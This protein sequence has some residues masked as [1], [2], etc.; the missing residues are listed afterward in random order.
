MAPP[1]RSCRENNGPGRKGL[2][3]IILRVIQEGAQ[4][5]KCWTSRRGSLREIGELNLNDFNQHPGSQGRAESASPLL[6]SC[7]N[8][9]IDHGCDLRASRWAWAIIIA[10][11]LVFALKI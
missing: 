9:H 3:V 11:G 1:A 6:R 5:W 8:Q 10:A 7:L 4:K 2:A